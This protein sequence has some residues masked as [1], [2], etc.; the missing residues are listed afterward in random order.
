MCPAKIQNILH[1]RFTIAPSVM[2]SFYIILFKRISYNYYFVFNN[3]C[4][5]I[6]TF[7]L[8]LIDHTQLKYIYYVYKLVVFSLEITKCA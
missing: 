1:T 3:L 4:A 7:K 5:V 8:Y 2:V 6:E